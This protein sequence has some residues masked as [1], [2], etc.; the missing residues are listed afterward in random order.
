MGKL[1]KLLV[2]HF[3]SV[4]FFRANS[5]VFLCVFRGICARFCCWFSIM[6]IL[7][8]MA[9]L[10]IRD[11]FGCGSAALCQSV[12]KPFRSPDHARSPD[13]PIFSAS[14]PAYLLFAKLARSTSP[15]EAA[16]HAQTT[17]FPFADLPGCRPSVYPT[18][19]CPG[20][21]GRSS[22]LPEASQAHTRNSGCSPHTAGR[23]QPQV[24]LPSGC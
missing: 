9:I 24:R 13:L 16:L 10:A 14:F 22:R 12:V 11:K 18:G 17:E 23:G 5:S 15:P 2:G 1:G 3:L 4:F 20:T 8:V 19:H 7:A 6:A 21:T